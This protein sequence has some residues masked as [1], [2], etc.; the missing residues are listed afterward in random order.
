MKTF[1]LNQAKGGP[2]APCKDCDMRELGCHGTCDKYI[3]YRKAQDEILT[4]RHKN[5]VEK[6][7]YFAHKEAKFKRIRVKGGGK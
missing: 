6:D 1:T 3:T 4:I 2:K 5:Y 7:N